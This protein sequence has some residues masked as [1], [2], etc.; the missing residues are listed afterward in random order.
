M[1][2]ETNH[3]KGLTQADL[4]AMSVAL[5]SRYHRCLHDPAEYALEITAVLTHA[6]QQTASSHSIILSAQ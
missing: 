2:F 1:R 3:V 4:F 6:M 5:R